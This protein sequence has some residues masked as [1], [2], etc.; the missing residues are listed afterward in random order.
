LSFSRRCTAPTA[1]VVWGVKGEQQRRAE[2]QRKSLRLWRLAGG[3]LRSSGRGC[4][5][6]PPRLSVLDRRWFY[7]Y[8]RRRCVLGSLLHYS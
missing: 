2:A 4:Y 1:C 7:Y 3:F 5:L 6:L 8:C